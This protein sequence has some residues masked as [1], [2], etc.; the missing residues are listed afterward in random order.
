MFIEV[1]ES[2]LHEKGVTAAKMLSDFGLNKSSVLNLKTR[3]TVPSGAILQKL[4]D[5]FGVSVDYL[6][7]KSDEKEKS[8][9]NLKKQG[10]NAPCFL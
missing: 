2:L 10:A 9:N 4:A 5:Y 8:Q 7:G 3:G 1:L 6:L